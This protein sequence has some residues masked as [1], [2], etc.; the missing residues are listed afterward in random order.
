M[1]DIW[2]PEDI[3]RLGDTEDKERLKWRRWRWM[4]VI[5]RTRTRT[6]Y[7]NNNSNKKAPWTYCL[8]TAS[9]TSSPAPP[10][11]THASCLLF[12]KIFRSAADSDVVWE[13]FLPPEC[14]SIISKFSKLTLPDLRSKK[15]LSPPTWTLDSHRWWEKGLLSR[16]SFRGLNFRRFDW[17]FVI[18]LGLNYLFVWCVNKICR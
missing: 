13:R 16:F 15:E 6:A 12:S 5:S 11:V 3:S 8:K 17:E 7:N 4:R 9:P 18:F 14:Q 2:R 1:A 10:L